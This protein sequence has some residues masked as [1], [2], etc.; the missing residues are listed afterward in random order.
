MIT[1][2]NLFLMFT[3]NS[4][5]KVFAGKIINIMIKACFKSFS[6]LKAKILKIY[7]STEI[8]LLNNTLHNKTSKDCFS[9][10][11]HLAYS[12][13]SFGFSPI[14]SKYVCTNRAGIMKSGT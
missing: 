7:G 2:L 12:H 14:T 5:F 4:F 9:F 3:Y 13:R 1:K 11:S 6:F 8:S 10:A